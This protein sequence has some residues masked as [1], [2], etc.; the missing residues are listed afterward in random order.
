[1]AISHEHVKELVET[2]FAYGWTIFDPWSVKIGV[3]CVDV[4]DAGFACN[5]CGLAAKPELY[6]PETHCQ[7]LD[8]FRDP[9]NHD[10]DCPLMLLAAEVL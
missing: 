5:A 9:K 8:T 2:M 7:T 6:H 1:V 3:G 10:P 4:V